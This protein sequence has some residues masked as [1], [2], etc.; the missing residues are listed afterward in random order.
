MN[1]PID[2]A[3]FTIGMPLEGGHF[4]GFF[5]LGEQRRALISAP[6]ALGHHA[7]TIWNK[8]YKAVSGAL[9]FVDGLTNTEAMAKAGSEVAI[10]A[11][12]RSINGHSDWCI[13]ALDQLE[14][15]YRA[16]KPSND[17]NTLWGRSGLNASALPPTYPYTPNLPPMVDLTAFRPGGE[18]AFESEWHWSSTQ[19]AG[20]DVFAWAQLFGN[21]F[22]TITRK[23]DE[24]RVVL[25]R[26]IAI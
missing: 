13:P 20:Y 8:S 5:L 23:S 25:V 19:H 2:P 4:A 10:W 15:L 1:A 18:E 26:S 16:F 22:Q 7:P 12:D 3:A 21:G 6:K 14:L 24:F 17:D 9:S 11:R